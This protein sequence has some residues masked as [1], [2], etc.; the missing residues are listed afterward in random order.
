LRPAPRIS[1]TG[2][3]SFI[4]H[5]R[6]ADGKLVLVTLGR[7][8]DLSLKEARE[9]AA[10]QRVALKGGADLN[11]EKRARKAK[12]D[13]DAALGLDTAPALRALLWEYQALFAPWRA[14]WRPTGVRSE[15]SRLST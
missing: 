7:Y 3:V 13:A 15:R 8:P 9:L 12:A 14:I 1:P 11:A 5:I 4:L 6:N 2:E 10:R